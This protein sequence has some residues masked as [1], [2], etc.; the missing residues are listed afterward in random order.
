MIAYNICFTTLLRSLDGIDKDMY[1]YFQIEQEEPVDAKPPSKD[2]FDYNDY[3]QDDNETDS[4][5]KGKKVK[6][7]YEFG[8]VKKEKSRGLLPEILENILSERK[9]VKKQLKGTNKLVDILDKHIFTAYRN[10]NELTYGDITDSKSREHIKL[11]IN[12]ITDET[13]IKDHIDILKKNYEQL[14]VNSAVFDSRQLGLKVSANSIYGFLGAQTMGK[15][16]L[17]EGSMCVTSRGRELITESAEFFGREYNATTVYGDTDST[18][19]YV[20][21]LKN[22]PKRAWEMAE[23]MEKKING[24]PDEYKDGKLVKKGIK[25]IFPAPLYLEF[26]KAMRALFMKKKH[27]AYMTYDKYGN[28]DKEKNSDLFHLNVKGIPLARRD[29]CQWL[30]NTYERIIRKIFDKCSMKE[31]LQIIVNAIVAVIKCEFNITENLSIIKSMGSN[32]KSKTFYLSIFSEVMKSISRP[33]NPGERFPYVIVKD[34]QNRD[35]VGEKMRTNELFIEQWETSG[36]KY[37]DKIP[38]DFKSDL[39]LYPPEEIDSAYYITNIL[40]GPIDNLFEY[41]FKKELED[42]KYENIY[43]Q[44]SRK[45]LKRV[46]IK[47]PILMICQMMKDKKKEIQEE[48]I[49]YIIPYIRTIPLLPEQ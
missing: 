9:K 32:Y 29:N 45:A 20:P 13:K 36:Y 39:G 3:V 21:E 4:E 30:R 1:N 38:E 33:I 19:V 10:N 18:M 22:D 5:I 31:A 47:N 8:F 27:Y 12:D 48:G 28:I 43:Y 17:I 23:I 25:G 46:H 40:Q 24:T 37:G 14:Q 6:R 15:F 2:T 49:K 16:S 41:G 7:N 44:P 34:H 26:E 42:P 11:V 35:K